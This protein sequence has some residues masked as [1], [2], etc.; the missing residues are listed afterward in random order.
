MR[1]PVSLPIVRDGGNG[2]VRKEHV[3]QSANRSIY[4]SVCPFVRRLG[5]LDALYFFTE[6][7]RQS[8]LFMLVRVTW[9]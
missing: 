4:P 6:L 7:L 1:G 8:V 9:E 2:A 3:N 5:T